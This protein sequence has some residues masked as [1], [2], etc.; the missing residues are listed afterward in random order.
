MHVAQRQGASNGAGG[1]IALGIFSVF[2]L[3][4]CIQLLDNLGRLGEGLFRDRGLRTIGVAMAL[5]KA[6]VQ[7]YGQLGE[8]FARIAEGQAPNNDW[9]FRATRRLGVMPGPWPCY[10]FATPCSARRAR[11]L[12]LSHTR[13]LALSW[14]G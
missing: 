10:L 9:H 6:Y 13:A 4:L 5:S 7:V 1:A 12:L 11:G 3:P 2:E 8:V 14:V